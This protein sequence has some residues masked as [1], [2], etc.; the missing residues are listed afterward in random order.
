MAQRIICDFCG[1]NE[2]DTSYKIKMKTKGKYR[3]TWS[4]WRHIDICDK[5]IK[6]I[7]GK[8]LE[9]ERRFPTPPPPK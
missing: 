6:N 5:C 1:V 4:L 8:L 9:C 7:F 3:N 2:A